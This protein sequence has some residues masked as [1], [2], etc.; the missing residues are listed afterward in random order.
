MSDAGVFV[1]FAIIDPW[2]LEIYT[3]FSVKRQSW[4]LNCT[5][6][7]LHVTEQTLAAHYGNISREMEYSGKNGTAKEYEV[8]LILPAHN[9][10]N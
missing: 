5:H 9:K 7:E 2:V 1:A 3:Q 4:R 8:N 10:R 6:I